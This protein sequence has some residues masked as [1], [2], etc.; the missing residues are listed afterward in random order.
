MVKSSSVT[1]T[2][3][4]PVTWTVQNI[5]GSIKTQPFTDLN[6]AKSQAN[7][8]SSFYKETFI[9]VDSS[10]VTVYTATYTAPVGAFTISASS[11]SLMAGGSTVISGTYTLNGTP[12][13]GV[14][15]YLFV[16]GVQQGSTVTDASGNYSFNASFPTAGSYTVDVADDTTNT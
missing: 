9:V 11:T 12:A 10:G 8:N 5:S 6:S 1:I 4:A 14:T 7:Y 2:V 3:A 15:V 16:S 13:S